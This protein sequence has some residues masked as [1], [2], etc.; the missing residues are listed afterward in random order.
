MSMAKRLMCLF[1]VLVFAVSFTACDNQNDP[2]NNND[3]KEPT[4]SIDNLDF[5]G[6]TFTIQT[7]INV[8]TASFNSSNYLIQGADEVTGDKAS[9]SALQRNKKVETDLN[10]KL[11][12]LESDYE[13]SE[14]GSQIRELIKSGAEGIYLIINDVQTARLSSEGSFHDALYGKYFDFSQPYW[15]DKFM[16]TSSLNTN[17]RFLLAGDYFID[18]I[19]HSHCLLMNKDYYT[20]I[21]CDPNEIYQM[22]RNGDWTLDALYTIITGGE[23]G[24]HPT[25]QDIQGNHKRDRRDKWGLVLWQWWGP[26]IPWLTTSDPGYITRTA[27]GYPEITV[28]NERT[29]LM[30]EKLMALFNADETAVGIHND[31]QDTI[32]NFVEGNILFLT[33]QRLGSLESEIFASTTLDLG[34]LPYPKLDEFQENYISTIHDTTE[35]GFIP[36]TVSFQE[37]DY[38]SAVVEYLSQITAE[39]VTQKYYESTL[40]IR[41]ARESD[42]ADMIQIIHDSYGNAFPLIWE[43]GDS[44]IFTTG[45]YNSISTN[46]SVFSSYYRA[47]EVSAKASLQ[48][49]IDEYETI[50]EDMETAY[51]NAGKK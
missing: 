10:I 17:T 22:V 45:L 19:R 5:K 24:A 38:V 39:T 31:N 20:E 26:M 15:Y 11:R 3:T 47:N 29:L 48:K 16:E 4:N 27:E 37:L 42:N 44:N 40:K 1:L 18:V 49:L 46:Q 14:V 33:Y 8:D 25:Y 21:G 51:A 23:D 13:Y 9:D 36:S 32:D 41:Y 12:Y 7:S 50:R 6:A 28:N 35:V 43:F 34:V 30:C 2:G